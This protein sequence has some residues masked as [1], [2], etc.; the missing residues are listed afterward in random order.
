ME[1]N[2]TRAQWQV[3]FM[4]TMLGGVIALGFLIYPKNE[5]QRNNL[6]AKLGTTNHGNFVVPPISI[7]DLNLKNSE[8]EPWDFSDQKP[9]W[10]LVIAG[11]RECQ[12]QC[13]KLLY[14]TRQVHIS[15]GKYSR[16]F[17]RLYIS[18]DQNLSTEAMDF[19]KLNHP[20]LKLIYGNETEFEAMLSKTDT[21]FYEGSFK[22]NRAYLVDQKGLIM[23]SYD[24]SHKGT[25]IIEDIEHL[26]KYSAQ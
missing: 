14:L 12:D 19:L 5:D 10:R 15:L 11:D 7:R 18:L 26:M 21:P 20:F 4:I 8:S 2:N 25:E 6:L 1:N 3:W 22:T 23:M 24:L 17:E 13:R 9:K 16:R